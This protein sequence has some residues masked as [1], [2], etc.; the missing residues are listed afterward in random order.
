MSIYHDIA[1]VLIDIEAELRYLGLW[2]QEEPDEEALASTEPFCVDTLD[3][4]QWLQFVFLP[5]MYLIVEARDMLPS[6]CGIAPMAEE[7][8]RGAE[9]PV[10]SLIVALHRVDRLLSG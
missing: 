5:R 3:L 10:E 6:E 9:L 4:H 8:Y 1:S 7:F 2:E